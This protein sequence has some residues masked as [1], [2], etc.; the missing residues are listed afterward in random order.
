MFQGRERIQKSLDSPQCSNLLST[1]SHYVSYFFFFFNK[2]RIVKWNLK[3]IRKHH[4]G[5]SVKPNWDS[6]PAVSVI[7]RC[8]SES[9]NR[10]SIS[11][12]WVVNMQIWTGERSNV[13]PGNPPYHKPKQIIYSFRV[14]QRI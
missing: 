14:P 6:F 2:S 12:N 4:L 10:K 13:S 3:G 7:Q 11:D 5:L 9:C 8:V 1:T